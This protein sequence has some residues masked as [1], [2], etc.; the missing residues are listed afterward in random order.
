M[1]YQNTYVDP[2]IRVGDLVYCEAREGYKFLAF[3]PGYYYVVE[4]GVYEFN[5]RKHPKYKLD[6]R[7][8]RRFNYE[9]Q[10]HNEVV[11]F[12]MIMRKV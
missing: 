8:Y 3:I 4:I 7:C 11:G 9:Q 6:R 12:E 1:V 10:N 2:D 5:Y